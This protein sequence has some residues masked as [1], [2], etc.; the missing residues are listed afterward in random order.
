MGKYGGFSGISGGFYPSNG[1]FVDVGTPAGASGRVSRAGV[2]GCTP[3][4]MRARPTPT[5]LPPH[6]VRQK[7]GGISS[8]W[9][10]VS[11]IECVY[12]LIFNLFIDIYKGSET[13]VFCGKRKRAVK[14]WCNNKS[15]LFLKWGINANNDSIS[16][17]VQKV[18]GKC[19]SVK[20]YKYAKSAEC[21]ESGIIGDKWQ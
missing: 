3:A 6:S 19:E 13:K 11:A 8:E 10:K 18:N 21:G 4:I 1:R 17:L 14:C 16:D 5:G 2:G 7:N 20:M 9:C 15:S 12:C